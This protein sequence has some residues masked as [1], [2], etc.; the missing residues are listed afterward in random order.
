MIPDKIDESVIQ[1]AGK[2]L[3]TI[4]TMTV[5]F[6]HI[7]V[8]ACKKNKIPVGHTPRNFY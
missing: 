2:P 7:D 6:D 3:K 8:E 5:G 4:S 1:A